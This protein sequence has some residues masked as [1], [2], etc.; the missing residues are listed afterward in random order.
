MIHTLTKSAD[1]N[2][3]IRERNE[4]VLKVLCQLR[5]QDVEHPAI[6]EEL[7]EIKEAA[8][9]EREMKMTRWTELLVPNNL[10]R[11]FIGVML[12]VL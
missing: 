9:L 5:N 1:F 7:Q 3:Q 6:V 12:Q 4:E 11:L 2:A 8:Q 10:R